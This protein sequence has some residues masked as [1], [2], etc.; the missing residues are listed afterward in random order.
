MAQFIKDTTPA[1]SCI[2]LLV[3]SI[4]I[5]QEIGNL[6]QSMQNEL[7]NTSVNKAQTTVDALNTLLVAA[8]TV[9]SLIS[10][11][12][13]TTTDFSETISKLLDKRDDLLTK[14]QDANKKV[15]VR[16]ENVKSLLRHEITGM[17]TNRNAIK[18]YK[19]VQNDRKNIVKNFF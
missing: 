1:T 15:V 6:Y 17:S 12:L 3:K 14:L 5:Y 7:S 13:E 9:D 19:P 2:A 10:L 16:V 11:D 8:R 18:G 4:R